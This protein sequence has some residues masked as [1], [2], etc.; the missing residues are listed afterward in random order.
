MRS[1]YRRSAQNVDRNGL[2]RWDGC[3]GLEREGLLLS[4]LVAVCDQLF[5]IDPLVDGTRD[6]EFTSDSVQRTRADR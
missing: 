6:I 5:V 1:L 3:L 2:W 4:Y